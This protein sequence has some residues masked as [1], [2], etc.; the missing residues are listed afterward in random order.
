MEPGYV[1]DNGYIDSMAV[2]WLFDSDHVF[3]RENEIAWDGKAHSIVGIQLNAANIDEAPVLKGNYEQILQGVFDLLGRLEGDEGLRVPRA[4]IHPA[5]HDAIREGDL[6]GITLFNL[7]ACAQALIMR[8]KEPGLYSVLHDDRLARGIPGFYRLVARM[9]WDMREY[10]DVS[11]PF[12]VAFAAA[13]NLDA[14]QCFGSFEGMVEG[15]VS[16]GMHVEHVDGRPDVGPVTVTAGTKGKA[17]KGSAAK[18]TDAKAK[19]GEGAREAKQRELDPDVLDAV[20]I[21]GLYAEDGIDAQWVVDALE[22]FGSVEDVQPY[23]DELVDE[24]ILKRPEKGIYQAATSYREY[25]SRRLDLQ[26]A[27]LLREEQYDLLVDALMEYGE[28]AHIDELEDSVSG[29]PKRKELKEL[30]SEGVS[31]GDLKRN[32]RT[33][34]FACALDGD[35]KD[36]WKSAEEKRAD[37]RK[38][39]RKTI[40][41]EREQ[42]AKSKNGD[43]KDKRRF[44][45][46]KKRRDGIL[47]RRA[48]KEERRQAE[49]DA[50]AMEQ[51]VEKIDGY[52]LGDGFVAANWVKK[53]V[54][55]IK[56]VKRAEELLELCWKKQLI[57]RRHKSK[58]YVY[59]RLATDE[60]WAKIRERETK[61]VEDERQERAEKQRR[62][63]LQKAD[64]RAKAAAKEEA[65]LVKK[66]ERYREEYEAATEH[67]VEC[68]KKVADLDRKILAAKAEIEGLEEEL[69]N[70]GIFA[71][72]K[73]SELGEKILRRKR[74]LSIPQREKEVAVKPVREAEIVTRRKKENLESSERKL[75]KIRQEIARFERGEDEYAP[76]K[77]TD[78]DAAQL[79][80]R[81]AEIWGLPF[82]V[83]WVRDNVPGMHDDGRVE[84]VMESREGKAVFKEAGPDTYVPK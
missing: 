2:A 68:R 8:Q 19:D 31:R 55:D 74:S 15:A 46:M 51:V 52:R 3:F 30:L 38:M 11:G 42:L 57:R 5:L 26:E 47:R 53:Q 25:A 83:Q 37:E 35:A 54:P 73:R 29:L 44:S 18:G 78:E 59:A 69:G 10:N 6:T 72:S 82:S 41:D 39:T 64:A 56:T 1:A 24:G 71:F 23:F 40:V 79:I 43:G 27:R 16:D 81:F 33:L 48:E 45:K 75:E 13:R 60:E 9:L 65:S 22:E 63:F 80:L 49:A 67:E 32:G 28:F 66:C 34:A 84:K 61:A 12:R 58:K 76:P 7:A 20:A 77:P 4:A 70:L 62:E 14:D 21:A 50:A 17:I 36:A